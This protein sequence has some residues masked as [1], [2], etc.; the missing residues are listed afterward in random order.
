MTRHPITR[1]FVVSFP[2]GCK[3][4]FTGE[5]KHHVNRADWCG[6]H[7][8]KDLHAE[9]RRLMNAAA[10]RHYHGIDQEGV[11]KEVTIIGQHAKG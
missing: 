11:Y 1:D 2:C 9:Q 7:S 10:A 4:T 5:S 3:V 6:H 8:Y